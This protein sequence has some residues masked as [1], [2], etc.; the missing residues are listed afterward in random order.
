MIEYLFPIG[1]ITVVVFEVLS[2]LTSIREFHIGTIIGMLM[3]LVGV[4]KL[5]IYMNQETKNLEQG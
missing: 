2:I 3:M 1:T 4:Y 5:I